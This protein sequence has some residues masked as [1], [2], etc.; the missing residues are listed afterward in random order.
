MII[1]SPSKAHPLIVAVMPSV[2]VLYEV[3]SLPMFRNR[4]VLV[5]WILPEMLKYSDVASGP[6]TAMESMVYLS[7]SG[8]ITK[9]MHNYLLHGRG[10]GRRWGSGIEC[11]ISWIGLQVVMEDRILNS[12]YLLW[13][14]KD[15]CE[16][17]D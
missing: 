1:V 17:K 14:R 12:T 5:D 13:L 11:T 9:G 7:K 3:E 4:L 15:A 6:I 8:M 10:R 16:G 2:S